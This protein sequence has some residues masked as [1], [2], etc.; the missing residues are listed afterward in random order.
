MDIL[1]NRYAR[2]RLSSRINIRTPL[3][4]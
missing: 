4:E 1:I 3:I 2:E